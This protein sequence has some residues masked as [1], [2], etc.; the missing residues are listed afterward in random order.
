MERIWNIWTVIWSAEP[1]FTFFFTIWVGLHLAKAKGAFNP[2]CLLPAVKNGGGSVI[3]RAAV[4]WE[5]LGPMIALH[6]P[7]MGQPFYR[8]RCALWCT[9]CSPTKSP[10]SKMITLPCTQIPER[11]REHL[12]E[13][14]LLPWP[15][16]SPDLCIVETLWDILECVKIPTSCI[17][18]RTGGFPF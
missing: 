5:S 7:I 15:P 3:V 9:H 14:E 4:S 6:G 12:D 17:P 2:R 10:Y 18:Q 11:F 16:Q 13:A 1:S 8:T